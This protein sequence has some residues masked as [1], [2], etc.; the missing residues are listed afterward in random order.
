MGLAAHILGRGEAGEAREAGVFPFQ[1]RC[2]ERKR[3]AAR[4]GGEPVGG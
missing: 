1:S 2:G 3:K 4:R